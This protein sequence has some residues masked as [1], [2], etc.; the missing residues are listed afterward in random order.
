MTYYRE[1]LN[2]GHQDDERAF[3]AEAFPGFEPL[4]EFVCPRC[5]S[6]H[7]LGISDSPIIRGEIEDDSEP[8]F[9]FY[10]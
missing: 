9:D 4:R 10:R 5:H 7:T 3:V 6:R 8:N 1:C 2:C